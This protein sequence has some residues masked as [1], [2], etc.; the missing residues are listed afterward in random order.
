MIGVAVV[1][2]K[3][4]PHLP[5]SFTLQPGGASPSCGAFSSALKVMI[6]LPQARP[7]PRVPGSRI[8]RSLRASSSSA[9]ALGLRAPHPRKFTQTD[10]VRYRSLAPVM[11]PSATTERCDLIEDDADLDFNGALP[12][13][14]IQATSFLQKEPTYDGRGVIIA[15]FDTG[16]DPGAAGLQTTST[17]AAKIVDVVDC[18]GS[19]D[20]DTS[21]VVE[22]DADGCIQSLYGNSLR[23]NP[24]WVNP[25]GNW[26]VGAKAAYELF[27]AGLKART[28]EERKRRWDEHQRAAV[29][30]ATS[31]VAAFAR[32][33]P[34]AA[35][36][37]ADPALKKEKEELDARVALLQEMSTTYDDVGPLIDAV[38][39]HDGNK[40]LAALDTSDFYDT[41]AEAD[42]AAAAG[43]LAAFAPL[44]NYRDCRQHGTFSAADALNFAVNIYDEGDTLS[45]VV[46]AGSHGTHVAGIAA[47]HHPED[48]ALNG[49]A[50]GAQ[51]VSC[52]IGDT[53]L[54]SME[55]MVGL[56][57]ALITVLENKCDLINMSYGEATATAN[58]GRFIRLAEEIVNEHD[59][60]FVASAGNAGPALSTVGAPG[61]TSSAILGIGA[62]VTPALAKSGH[63]L[64]SVAAAAAPLIFVL[65][66]LQLYAYPEAALASLGPNTHTH[67]SHFAGRRWPLG[68]STRGALGGPRRTATPASPSRPPAAPSPPSR[69]GP[70][71]NGS[72]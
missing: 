37:A 47:A 14:E 49:I 31:A 41:D 42:S 34:A 24:A 6:A 40:W 2:V 10:L 18:T 29:T 8:I 17:G 25:S 71:R 70:R 55:T 15:I 52:K 36:V 57:R 16:V 48:P 72:S 64:R 69:S 53:R 39:W 61:G 13:S 56:T 32:A 35:A 63:S 9:R 38:V 54:G 27:P 21:K 12:K 44:T 50:P 51:I 23:L 28:Q 20:V 4:L 19:G 66:L 7:P 3:H 22:A 67:L 43:A 1:K 5:P 30:A 26:R 60:I 68:R 11:P 46:D 45:L 62:F 33:H 59:V 65:S 58:A